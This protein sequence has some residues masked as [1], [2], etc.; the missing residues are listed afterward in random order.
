MEHDRRFLAKA[1]SQSLGRLDRVE[2]FL[3]RSKRVA[4]EAL[5]SC[6][7]VEGVPGMAHRPPKPMSL[8]SRV[9]IG[10]R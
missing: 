10:R 2:G 1:L 8:N 6:S 9:G 7:P 3:A 4:E 5:S